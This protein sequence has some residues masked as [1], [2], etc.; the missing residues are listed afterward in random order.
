MGV[1]EDG[2]ITPVADSEL[3]RKNY[4]F[5]SDARKEE[6]YRSVLV[7]KSLV[8]SQLGCS[9][10]DNRDAHVS[11]VARGATGCTSWTP[12][13]SMWACYRTCLP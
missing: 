1:L 4:Q 10:L 8:G 2:T 7:R 5:V 11:H 13:P 3:F 12:R 9:V 6:I